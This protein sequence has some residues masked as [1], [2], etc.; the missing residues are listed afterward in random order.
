MWHTPDGDR[1]LKGAEA[2]LVRASLRSLL[3]IVDQGSDEFDHSPLFGVPPFDELERGQRLVLLA[4]LSAAL[5]REDVPPMR[6]T[7]VTEAT[8]CLLY[9]NVMNEIEFE[10]EREA[11][12]GG[13][14]Q[15]RRW[16]RLVAAAS[17]EAEFG[18]S[19]AR[20]SDIMRYMASSPQ[21]DG[22]DPTEW[23]S[24]VSGLCDLVCGDRD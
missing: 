13:E 23:D 11:E 21:P 17:Y 16:R 12:F 3:R 8:V 2:R 6:L 4:Q 19:W 5:F 9:L 20:P 15:C 24:D 1:V 14:H 7:A 22:V 10:I 18:D